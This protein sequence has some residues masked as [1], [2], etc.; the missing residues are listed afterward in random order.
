MPNITVTVDEPTHRNVRVWAAI[1]NTT[2]SVLVREFHR[3]LTRDSLDGNQPQPGISAG[4]LEALVSTFNQRSPH[5]GFAQKQAQINQF[6]A[7]FEAL[8]IH[9]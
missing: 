9:K 2:A 3:L 6:S 7:F 1:H 8:K 4:H 5:P